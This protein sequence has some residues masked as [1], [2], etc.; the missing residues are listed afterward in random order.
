MRN[1]P[2]FPPNPL[3]TEHLCRYGRCLHNV[4]NHDVMRE[5]FKFGVARR[6]LVA[7]AASLFLPMAACSERPVA[8]RTL[9]ASECLTPAKVGYTG[10]LGKGWMAFQPYVRACP[11]SALSKGPPKVWLLTVFAQPWLDSHPDQSDWP[12]FPRPMLVTA[13]GHC[14]ARLPE[15]FPFDEPRTLSLRYAPAIDGMPAEIRV[16][17]SNPAAG[18]DYDLPVLKWMLQR[19]AYIAQNDTDEYNKDAMTC[20]H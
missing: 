2:D 3:V 15:L 8:L 9:S 1:Q 16:H 12:D 7:L 4:K 11:L 14:L 17:V 10:V 19:G 13:D 5:L 6:F 18:G 20:P